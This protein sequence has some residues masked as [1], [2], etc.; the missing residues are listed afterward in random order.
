MVSS[1]YCPTLDLFAQQ[2]GVLKSEPEPGDIFLVYDEISAYHTGFVLSLPNNT[3]FKT[4]EGNS[5]DN[6]SSNGDGIY[7]NIRTIN[8]NYRF[9]KW[10]KLLPAEPEPE[11]F[12]KLYIKEEF[13]S[14][15][16]LIF[17]QAYCPVRK[18]AEA[19]KLKIKVEDK[20]KKIFLS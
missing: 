6:G 9:I 13:I 7:S 3:Q 20:E 4:I 10:W 19:L 2:K 1:G 11:K 15:C 12:F 14:D 16:P 8:N 5:N 18:L 17:N